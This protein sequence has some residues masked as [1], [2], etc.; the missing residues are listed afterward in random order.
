M[1]KRLIC[2]LLVLV[3]SVGM[4]LPVSAL[5]DFVPSISYKDHPDV[6]KPPVLIDEEDNILHELEYPCL[7][8]TS[9]GE[10]AQTPDDEKT[11]ADKLLLDVYKQLTDGTMSLPFAE[12]KAENMVIRD[13]IDASLICGNTHT[14]PSHVEELAKPGVFI[15]ITFDLGVEPGTEVVVMAYIDGQWAPIH[16]VKN[17]GDGTVTC[18]FDQICPIAFCVE[19]K[20]DAPKTGDVAIPQ[21]ILWTVLLLGSFAAVV[22]LLLSKRRKSKKH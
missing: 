16:S 4:A 8:I 9:V 3:L 13:L 6:P 2:M 14:N 20:D 15:E 12:D 5:S 7:E 10:A 18:V 22:V 19:E 11:D 17:N 21:L 1:M